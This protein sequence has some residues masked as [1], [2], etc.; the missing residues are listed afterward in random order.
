MRLLDRYDSEHELFR[1][2][3]SPYLE[4]NRLRPRLLAI[5]KT[6]P[7]AYRAKVLGQALL[8]ARADVNSFWM[9]L[10][11]N[12]EVSFPSTTAT[13]TLFANLQI[14]A[15]V[16]ATFT[17]NAAP[18]VASNAVVPAAGQKRKTCKK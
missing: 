1:R 6:R 17:A 13:T 7:T 8:A 9:L 16:G 4:T 10:S 14:P 11:G 15:T 3:V 12:A 18:V 2:S 5:Q